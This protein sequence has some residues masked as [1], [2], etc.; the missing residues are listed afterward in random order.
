L[1]L[2]NINNK[3][4]VI[5]DANNFNTAQINANAQALNNIQTQVNQIVAINTATRNAVDANNNKLNNLILTISPFSS[6]IGALYTANG[7]LG[8]GA[9][10]QNLANAVRTV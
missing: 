8:V 2:A 10:Y 7:V 3:L 6:A 9:A 4:K 5:T 1:I